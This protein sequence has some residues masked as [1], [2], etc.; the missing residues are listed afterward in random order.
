MVKITSTQAVQCVIIPILMGPQSMIFSSIRLVSSVS[1]ICRCLTISRC[2][3]F[4]V[5]AESIKAEN[6]ERISVNSSTVGIMNIGKGRYGVV[7]TAVDVRVGRSSLV[8]PYVMFS[9]C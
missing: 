2:M 7:L 8:D 6:T 5:A 1:G 3:K 4:P 9:L